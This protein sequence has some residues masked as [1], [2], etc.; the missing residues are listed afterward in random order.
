MLTYNAVDEK[1]VFKQQ[2]RRR[3]SINDRKAAQSRIKIN[4]A[5]HFSNQLTAHNSQ[6]KA[7]IAT[8]SIKTL[9]FLAM[10]ALAVV[11]VSAQTEAR[12]REEG[13]ESQQFTLRCLS[14]R[15]HTYLA[16]HSNLSLFIVI[17][18][19][20]SHVCN[21][22]FLY[23]HFYYRF[24]YIPGCFRSPIPISSLWFLWCKALGWH[25]QFQYHFLCSCSGSSRYISTVHV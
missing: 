18:L 23:S 22:V 25:F 16:H 19:L 17:Y 13:N 21:F 1:C 11:S 3:L 15:L 12:G 4:L 9:L 2:Q 10:A 5:V 8:M 24:E 6:L 14:S 7:H 20:G